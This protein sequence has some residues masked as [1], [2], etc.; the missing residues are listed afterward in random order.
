MGENQDGVSCLLQPEDRNLVA[1]AG[2]CPRSDLR[3]FRSRTAPSYSTR[4]GPAA[5]PH[6]FRCLIHR[7]LQTRF[8]HQHL[9][10]WQHSSPVQ[11]IAAFLPLAVA[12]QE[13]CPQ[14][15]VRQPARPF[16]AL[17]LPNHLALFTDRLNSTF[18]CSSDEHVSER[19]PATG[20][21]VVPT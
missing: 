13:S 16:L 15:P 8:I 4:N 14:T 2:R 20:A 18:R 12:R 10:Q 6:R 19:L 1:H 21:V 11:Y 9:W 3:H 17:L 5:Y 7:R